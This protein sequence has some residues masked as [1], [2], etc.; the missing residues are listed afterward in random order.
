MTVE[1][2]QLWKQKLSCNHTVVYP[3]CTN[4]TV[5]SYIKRK[6]ETQKSDEQNFKHPNPVYTPIILTFRCTKARFNTNVKYFTI[7][8]FAFGDT[9]AHV[10][11]MLSPLSLLSN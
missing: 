4:L 10:T 5:H 6:N 9:Y 8:K 1:G 7:T 3:A 2:E 11:V